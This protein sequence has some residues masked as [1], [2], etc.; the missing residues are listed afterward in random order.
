[1]CQFLGSRLESPA[2]PGRCTDTGGY[3][4]NA[5]IQEIINTYSTDP[6]S[7]R[8]QA[9]VWH[10]LDS[11]TDMLLYDGD[12]WVGYMTD[13]TKDT[14]RQKWRE[15]N[16]G[17]T[18]DWGKHILSP[19]LFPPLIFLPPFILFFPFFSFFFLFLSFLS[20]S[21]LPFHC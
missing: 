1:M 7:P 19:F 17:G 14:R 20:F 11:N 13:L 6:E 3:I 15:Y 16:F 4:S 12:E 21:V 5:E 18:I 10:D 2:A 9:E 8:P